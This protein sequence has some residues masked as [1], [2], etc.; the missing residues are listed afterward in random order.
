MKHEN[1]LEKAEEEEERVS[2]RN[3]QSLLK[4]IETLHS[5][6]LNIRITSPIGGDKYGGDFMFSLLEKV[7]V[8]FMVSIMRF[9]CFTFHF[10]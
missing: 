10:F 7:E 4:M 2:I 1:L 6:M 3:V 9:L 8:R 5:E